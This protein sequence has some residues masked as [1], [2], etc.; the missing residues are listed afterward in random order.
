MAATSLSACMRPAVL[1][2]TGAPPLG[3]E[4]GRCCGAAAVALA[5]P[6]DPTD[7]DA[8][9][10]VMAMP[11]DV[12]HTPVPCTVPVPL[13]PAAA[14]ILRS[15]SG[16]GSAETPRLGEPPIH[17]ASNASI[18]RSTSPAVSPPPPMA[19]LSV[20]NPSPSA[21]GDSATYSAWSS[22]RPSESHRRSRPTLPSSESGSIL[23]RTRSHARRWRGLPRA[24]QAPP[25]RPCTVPRRAAPYS[26][27]SGGG[28][29]G[30]IP[31]DSMRAHAAAGGGA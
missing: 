31:A 30:T 22:G 9:P 18:R 7:G 24:D 20:E 21:P 27:K 25:R 6:G 2:G 8:W 17:A 1:V 13:S 14:V 15:M 4:P 12:T 19:P 3:T 29:R 26:T 5:S 28:A 11:V 16:F 23:V 10:C